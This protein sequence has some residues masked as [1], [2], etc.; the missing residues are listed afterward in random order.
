MEISGETRLIALLGDPVDHSLSPRMHNTA[1]AHLGLKYAYL[2][3]R[4]NEAELPAAV[5]ALKAL[6]ARGFNCTMPLKKAILPLLDDMSPA[7]RMTGSVNTVAIEDGRL[8]GHNT[9]GKGYIHDL[10][11]HGV[12][13]RGK[14]I[15]IVGAGGA[16]RGLCVQLA[17]DGAAEIVIAN[18]SLEK[19]QSIRC[20]IASNIP[21]CKVEAIQLSERELAPRIAL[22]DIFTNTTALGMHPLEESCVISNSAMLRPS[23]VMT[24]LVYIPEK[25][26]FLEFA[27]EAGCKVI[28]GAGML[29]WQ[30]AEA[31]RIWTG[32]DM[33]VDLVKRTVF[34]DN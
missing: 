34:P 15:L 26:I 14:R 16:A 5:A 28:N 21:T 22:A 32:K 33:P 25:T 10:R 18:R 8:I 24:D 20:L 29:L 17:L 27:E 9:D 4:S 7:A 13:I 30:G 19:A 23:L 11:D 6:D 1:F 31:F 2:A 12:E 3:F